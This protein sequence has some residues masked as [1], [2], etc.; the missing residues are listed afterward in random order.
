MLLA[1]ALTFL[2]ILLTQQVMVKYGP[3]PPAP[4]S[5]A[6]PPRTFGARGGG[7]PPQPPPGGPAPPSVEMA[8]ENPEPMAAV[9]RKAG[10]TGRREAA[11]EAE[12]VIEND[13]YRVVF[14]NRGAQVKSWVLK[15]YKDDKGQQLELVHPLAAARFGFPLSLWTY[16][17]ELRQRLNDVLYVASQSGQQRAPATLSFEFAGGGLVARKTFSFDHS[18]VIRVEALVMREGV[19]VQAYPA[20]PAGFG[21]QTGRAS[22]AVARVD[23]Q[24]GDKIERRN[25]KKVSGGET[26]HGP[27]HWA[28]TLD[29][30]FAAVFLPEEPDA[31]AMVTLHYA[32]DIPKDVNKPDPNQTEKVSVLGAAVGDAR[33]P[34]RER[35]FV[36]PKAIDVLQSVRASTTRE[37]RAPAGTDAKNPDLGPN[38]EGLVDFGWF[39]FI[40]KPLFLW[41][42]WTHEH[43]VQNWGWAIV[44]LTVIINAALLPLK[45][46]SMKAALKQQRVA[47]QINAIKQ[48]Y[49]KYK[50]ND[51][52]RAEMNKEVAALY[53]REGINPVGGCFPLLLQF[54]FLVAFYS[55]LGNTIELRHAVWL[56]IRDLSSPDPLHVIPVAIVITMFWLQKTTP[57]IGMDPMQQRMMNVMMPLMI[58][59]I[60]WTLASGLGLY[61]VMGNLLAVVQQYGINSSRFGREMRSEMEKR[62]RKKK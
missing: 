19:P 60:S 49:S 53:K 31:A 3:K 14:T 15:N 2:V 39:G 36:G 6:S 52:R 46:T 8:H 24:H 42:K 57:N 17:E 43:W 38:L 54:P 25:A 34:T 28:G 47:P 41:L 61:W 33:G 10:K 12:S 45:I 18:Y 44:I 23:W 16:D 58:G 4:G 21:D 50:L 1:F 5:P 37:D 26:I 22:F 32:L 40:A 48:K 20:W 13:L 59:G 7:R 29:Q 9:E 51:P 55:M 35:L 27:F 56:W 11:D 30:Y 62:A